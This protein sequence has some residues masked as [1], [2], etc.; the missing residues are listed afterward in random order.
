MWWALW[1]GPHP[2]QDP[3]PHP[4]SRLVCEEQQWKRFRSKEIFPPVDLTQSTSLLLAEATDWSWYARRISM[5]LLFGFGFLLHC[6]GYTLWGGVQHN[7]GGGEPFKRRNYLKPPHSPCSN[8]TCCLV[9]WNI[10][11]MADN[12]NTTRC[13]LLPPNFMPVIIMKFKCQAERGSLLWHS[14]EW[15]PLVKDVCVCVYREGLRHRR[16]RQLAVVSHSYS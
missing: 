16:D 12:I 9:K 5:T 11:Y 2:G 15:I 14:S 7:S 13:C 10:Y 1:P 3:M 6:R 4:Q 8:L